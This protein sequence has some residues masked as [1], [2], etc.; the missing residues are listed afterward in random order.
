MLVAAATVVVL[1]CGVVALGWAAAVG[2][3]T[4]SGSGSGDTASGDADAP[5]PAAVDTAAVIDWASLSPAVAAQMQYVQEHWDSTE[6]EEFG[7]IAENDCMDFASQSLLA[8]GW[9]EDDEWWYAVGDAYTSSVAWRSSTAF[10]EYL[11]ARPE[12]ATMLTDAQRDEVKVGDIVQFDWDVSG[13]RDHTGI[14]TAIVT[15]DDGSIDIEYAGHT[16]HTWDRSVD[17]SLTVQ[18]PGAVA[19]YWSIAD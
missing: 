15:K 6:S 12:K 7:Y 11:L 18:H 8:R 9:L 14:V 4:A 16:D 3:S 19:Y 17:W 1:L 13:D 5:A 2:D 10:M